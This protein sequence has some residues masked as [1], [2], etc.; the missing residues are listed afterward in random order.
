[1]PLGHGIIYLVNVV[2]G[3]VVFTQGKIFAPPLWL[4]A[5][6]SHTKLN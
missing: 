1:M 4:E 3:Q 5:S 6:G 2:F